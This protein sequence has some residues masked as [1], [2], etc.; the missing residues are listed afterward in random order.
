MTARPLG[1]LLSLALVTLA[2]A[3]GPAAAQGGAT[4]AQRQVAQACAPDI[5][6]HCPNVERGDGR[7]AACLQ[8]NSE[9]LSPNCRQALSSQ[10]R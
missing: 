4:P 8:Q 7:I 5:R 3:A 10:Q 9:R 1:R 6:A 2:L